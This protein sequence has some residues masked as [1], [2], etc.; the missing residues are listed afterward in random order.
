MSGLPQLYGQMRE[1]VRPRERDGL[2]PDVVGLE[3]P[4]PGLRDGHRKGIIGFDGTAHADGAERTL[5]LFGRARA[6]AAGAS[7]AE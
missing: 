3:A 1:A 4:L 7:P 2:S 6:H 5:E